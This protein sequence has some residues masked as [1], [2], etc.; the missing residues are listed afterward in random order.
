M[1]ARFKGWIQNPASLK[2]LKSVGLN[3][4]LISKAIP[5][6]KEAV[7]AGTAGSLMM[8]AENEK[9]GPWAKMAF[10]ILGDLSAMGAMGAGKKLLTPKKTLAEVTAA[11]SG[12]NAKQAWVSDLITAANESGIQLDAGSITQSPFIK[13]LQAH[14]TQSGLTGS[15]MDDFRKNLSSSIMREYAEVAGKVGD[16]AFENHEQASKAIL[17]ALKTE[18]QNL[19]KYI[20]PL[21]HNGRS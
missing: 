1:A 12:K 16:L 15:A 17:G 14:A 7:R 9:L 6:L 18:E 5:E 10:G 20:E 19:M 8:M 21:S 11:F 2:E 13:M 4:E 3:K